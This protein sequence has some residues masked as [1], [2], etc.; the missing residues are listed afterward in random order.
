MR[1]STLLKIIFLTFI[2]LIS[3]SISANNVAQDDQPYFSFRTGN[4][5]FIFPREY[6]NYADKVIQTVVQLTEH[7]EKIYDFS[8]DE[9]TDVIIA[10]HYSQI[11]NG[12]ATMSPNSQT[13]MYPGGVFLFDEFATTNWLA[14]LVYHEL[15]HLYQLSAKT[16]MF[17][18][19]TK[20]VFG[21]NWVNFIPLPVNLFPFLTVPF[22]IFTFPNVLLPDFLLEGNAVFN[23][24]RF[25][26][27][28]RL[29]SG[30]QRA[31]LYRLLN[32][33][34]IDDD[35]IINNIFSFPFGREKYIYGGYFFSWLVFTY[36]Q[37]MANQFFKYH[38]RHY[39]NPLRLS[40]S[41]DS[42][43][44]EEIS[45]I[46]YDSM[47]AHRLNAA[48]QVR[49]T[50]GR[51]IARSLVANP[52]NRNKDGIFFLVNED[53]THE[54][55]IVVLTK[56]GDIRKS[57]TNLKNGKLFF[58]DN[59]FYSAALGLVDRNKMLPALWGEN[60]RLK[61]GSENKYYFDYFA[62]DF[63][64][65]DG[66]KSME[67]PYIQLLNKDIGE[68]FSSALIHPN[69][70]AVYFKQEGKK[71]TLMRGKKELL[72]YKGYYGKPVDIFPTGGILF[73][74]PTQF[75]TGLYLFSQGETIKIGTSDLVVDAR[76]LKNDDFLICEANENGYE[77]KIIT[78]KS[79]YRPPYE[80][81]YFFEKDKYRDYIPF[82]STLGKTTENYLKNDA[83]FEY[84]S[85][86]QLRFSRFNF[87]FNTPIYGA[88]NILADAYFVDPLG[89]NS[90]QAYGET[91]TDTF[92][93]K[94]L[95][96]YW[97][98]KRLWNFGGSLEIENFGESDSV[99]T[100]SDVISLSA[101]T[102]YHIFR[103]DDWDL[104]FQAR[105]GFSYLEKEFYDT[106]FLSLDLKRRYSRS[107]S[108]D[109][110]LYQSL[111]LEVENDFSGVVVNSQF[112]WS[113][114]YESNWFF[115]FE[116]L[117]TYSNRLLFNFGRL[118]GD[119]ESIFPRFELVA[120]SLDGGSS[121][122]SAAGIKKV[123][124]VNSYNFFF[125]LAL[126]RLG[127]NPFLGVNVQ[128][129]AKL[130]YGGV[131]DA[132]LLVAHRLVNRVNINFLTD[133]LEQSIGINFGSSF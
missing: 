120:S 53:Q 8:L 26:Y 73:V 77:Y 39:I 102:R 86:A 68:V 89:F 76:W 25:G 1:E 99:L 129:E 46:F 4:Y 42:Y 16:S 58:I 17:S 19:F 132:E 119:K 23:E 92:Y 98:T 80:Y 22:P 32:Q 95:L 100:S 13:V 60:K 87:F 29:Y 59:D 105:L 133:G 79:Y 70:E 15:S 41:M 114:Y 85:L 127:I 131:L 47:R 93:K 64:W 109:P 55:E 112:S 107:L 48:P 43:F 24:S 75:G 94:G 63:L 18:R 88:S 83:E 45:E 20:Y 12:Y 106:E 6:R 56:D 10:S 33:S 90:L 61:K 44:N 82:K 74:A 54:G 126:R 67:R 115:Q 78:A 130:Y 122:S 121:F 101:L 113:E 40:T 52:M 66:Q 125:P 62:G 28:G 81:A 37:D 31:I 84:D 97:N 2:I 51:V 38:T 104:F 123:F 5:N 21:N 65:A 96:T 124:N 128:D 57:R 36:G 72:S 108:F 27:G 118:E 117:A 111:Y 7:Y 91:N 14:T 50:R 49:N 103:K 71:R 69:G 110:F 116:S 11:G 9:P 3:K 30:H 35:R 34:L